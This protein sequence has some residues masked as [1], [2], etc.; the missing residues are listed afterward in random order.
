MQLNTI[1]LIQ[2]LKEIVPL[3]YE[4]SLRMGSLTIT[5]DVFC[6]RERFFIFSTEEFWNFSWNNGYTEL[7]FT[8]EFEK[9]IWHIDQTIS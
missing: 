1:E 7:E 2:K 8:N 3:G 6:K 9:W 4:V 5:K